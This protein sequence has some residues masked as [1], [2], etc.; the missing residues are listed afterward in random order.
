MSKYHKYNSGLVLLYNK[1]TINKST[2]IEISFD[3]GSRC[4]GKLPGLSHFCEHMFFSGTD[5]LSKQE[6]TKRYFDFIKT[7]AYTSTHEIV[8]TGSILT[9]KLSQYLYAVYDMICN[10][11]FSKEAVAEEQKI[12]IQ[13][14][15]S[16]ADNYPRHA[17]CAR[18]CDI[19]QLPFYNYR[20]VGSKE[21]VSEI[22][23]IDVKRYVKKYFVNNNCTISICTPLSFGKVKKLIKNNFE[24][25]MPSNNLTPL[26]NDMEKLINESKVDMHNVDIDKNFLALT[27]MFKLKGPDL[28]SKTILSI[29]GNMLDD[30][31]DGLTKE[32]RIENSLIYGMSADWMVNR[33]NSYL[34]LYTELSSKNI[35]PCIDISLEY[36]NKIINHGFTNEQLKKELEKDLYY[37]H[38]KVDTPDSL[39]G[40]LQRYRE[41]D[42]FV[43]TK[44][45]HRVVK[46][47][48]L[49]EVN[50]M[51][52]QLFAEASIHIFV[53]GNA[54]KK[55]M[56]TLNQIKNKF[57]NRR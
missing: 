6:V 51:L 14:I 18:K 22:R 41:Y 48:T 4:D 34:G 40:S 36:I 37:W 47:I 52:K 2:S 53:Y 25:L 12:V 29:I 13:E 20:V 33:A 19:F 46:S 55:D 16:D 39:I 27:F 5:K 3:C 45:I 56:Y 9:S 8:F 30:I 7:N 17:N 1:N 24:M 23:S 32:L 38:T 15:V 57:K 44:D 11:T 54:D 50:T 31:S 43:S 28:R 35:K 26:V 42:K 21:S 49:D 10:S